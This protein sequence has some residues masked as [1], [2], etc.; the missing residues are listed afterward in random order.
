MPEKQLWPQRPQ[1][2]ALLVRSTQVPLHAIC[3]VGHEHCV[4]LQTPPTGHVTH[5]PPQ[6]EPPLH[7]TPHAFPA[8]VADPLPDDGPEHAWHAP[9][10]TP[11]PHS[12]IDC[13][14]DA[15]HPAAPQHPFGHE[16]ALQPTHAPAAQ[17]A[18]APHVL[19]SLMLLDG[20]H[21]GPAEHDCVPLLHGRPAGE[22]VV[23]ALQ[24][25]HEPWPLHTPFGTLAV[26][27]DVPAGATALWSV[28]V[29]VPPEH[30][31]T[32]PVS[33][34]FPGGEQGAPTVHEL[35]MPP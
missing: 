5:A 21:T 3:P 25:T 23:L 11:V 31:V 27:H 19:P 16:L 22:H 7:A 30:A 33:Q 4:P 8:H 13:A 32:L 24:L 12:L 1:F 10:L 2:V 15:T 6:R 17:M 9:P 26:V 20:L 18:P 29:G 35:Q 14:A 34:G 28:Q